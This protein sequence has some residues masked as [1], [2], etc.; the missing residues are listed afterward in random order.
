MAAIADRK[1]A[2]L[3]VCGSG[4][5]GG[6]CCGLDL[7]SVPTA[8][9][10]GTDAAQVE[11]MRS[12]LRQGDHA[13]AGSLAIEVL[14]EVPGHGEA[15]HVLFNAL[16]RAEQ[17]QAA[18]AVVD[19][20]AT[21]HLNDPVARMTAVQY[22]LGRNELPRAFFHARML[23]RLAPEAVVSHYLM[24]KTFLAAHT[25]GA[26]EHHFRMAL[27]PRIKHGPPVSPLEIEGSLAVTLR[28][29]GR[30]EE[31]RAILRRLDE[32]NGENLTVLLAWAELEEAATEFTKSAELLDRA[33][34]L[35]PGN[36]H[37]AVAKAKLLRRMKQ[38]EQALQLL[39]E[40]PEGGNID[41]ARL[42]E[43][44]QTL[45]AMGRYDEAFAMFV[46]CK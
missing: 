42:I 45:D 18:S 26:A 33:V 2:T 7:R 8:F 41:A 34:A 35:A 37:I 11:A 36:A 4:L 9:P 24:G 1:A 13:T 19:R 20:L 46:A 12:A 25:L 10:D 40:E 17:W 43:R 14:E 38:P 30:F 29:Q 15:L 44:G 21:V 16:R 6:R 28:H 31:A 22:L 23:I 5:S 3:C 32:E 39:E 27:H